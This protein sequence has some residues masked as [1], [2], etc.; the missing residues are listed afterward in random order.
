MSGFLAGYLGATT[1]ELAEIRRAIKTGLKH[2]KDIDV[3]A[4]CLTAWLKWEKEPI[5]VSQAKSWARR[6]L[7]LLPRLDKEFAQSQS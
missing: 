6:M 5:T 3:L 4:E 7:K 2:V 1:C